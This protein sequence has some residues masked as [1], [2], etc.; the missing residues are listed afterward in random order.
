MKTHSSREVAKLLGISLKS[1]QRYIA[2]GKISVPPVQYVGGTKFRA[3][4]DRDV[5]KVR[6]QLLKI[7]NGRRRKK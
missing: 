3:W 7:K 5:E 1:L 4:T 2:A 6:K